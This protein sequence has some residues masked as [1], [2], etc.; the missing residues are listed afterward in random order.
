M[1]RHVYVFRRGRS[2]CSGRSW[3]CGFLFLRRCSGC[4]TIGGIENHDKFTGLGFVAN[5][6]FNLFND[7]S[8]R[9]RDFHRGFVTLYGDQ[10]LF[11]FNFVANFDQEFR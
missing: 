6:D 10:R 3:R 11:S 8:L 1:F 7:A 9:R 2:R 4:C 5:G